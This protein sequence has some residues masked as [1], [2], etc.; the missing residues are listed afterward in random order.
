MYLINL[1]LFSACAIEDLSF[2]VALGKKFN[3][4]NVLCY[5]KYSYVWYALPQLSQIGK[6]ETML[7]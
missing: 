2:G 5:V 3:Q 6:K 1:L 4:G 7:D